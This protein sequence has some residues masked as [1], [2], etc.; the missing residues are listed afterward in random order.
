M[1]KENILKHI[2]TENIDF[3]LY[4]SVASTNDLLKQEALKGAC[5]N[6]IIAALSQTNGRGR[7]GKTF[8]SNKG[9]MYLS[10]LVKPKNLDFDTTLITSAT[11]VAVCKAIEQI[12]NQ[13]TSIKWVNDVLID[14]KKVCG[15]LCESAIC[16]KDNFVIVGIGLNFYCSEFQKE[17]REVAGC[18]FKTP[19]TS[20]FEVLTAKIIDNFFEVYNSFDFLEDY[21]KRSIV[22]NKEIFVFK[23][24]QKVSAIA[25]GLDNKCRLKVRYQNNNNEELLSC[26]EISIKIKE[27]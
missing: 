22:L 11:A 21:I 10:I 20:N 24:G 16:G 27:L 7:K 17:I 8:I 3:S 18:I 1:K 25:L 12:T 2:K 4:D 9:G 15:I 13:K 5:E 14:G 26:G 23:N 6:R 19:E